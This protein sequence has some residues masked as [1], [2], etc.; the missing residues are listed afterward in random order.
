MFDSEGINKLLQENRLAAGAH[1]FSSNG[2]VLVPYEDGEPMSK[3][4][5][6]IGLKEDRETQ[7]NILEPIIQSEEV[8]KSYIEEIEG[9]IKEME[10]KLVT[11]PKKKKDYDQN[12]V[13]EPEIKRLKNVLAQTQDISIRNQAELHRINL[14]IKI[15]NKRIKELES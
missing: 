8:N 12:K 10:S 1:I 13:I 6:L 2:E 9:K 4:I 5:R 14:N 3:T 7:V 11:A 15:Y